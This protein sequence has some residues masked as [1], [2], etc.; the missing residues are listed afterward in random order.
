MSSPKDQNTLFRFTSLRSPELV[1]KNNQAQR[2]VFHPYLVTE[3]SEVTSAYF[4]AVASKPSDQSNWQAMKIASQTFTAYQS[5]SEIENLVPD[6]YYEDAIFLAKNKMSLDVPEFYTRISGYTPVTDENLV[7]VW[8]N[9]FY[10]VITQ[11]DFYIKDAILE[12]LVFQNLLR[13]IAGKT[14]D[15][16]IALI[17]VLAKA[18]VVLPNILF[19][20]EINANIAS[21]S[22]PGDEEEGTVLAAYNF[23]KANDV[24]LSQHN[25]ELYT[26]TLEKI[27]TVEGLLAKDKSAKYKEAKATHR[28]KVKSLLVPYNKDYLDAKRLLCATAPKPGYD[29]DDF[30][31]QPAIDYPTL[32]DFDFKYTEDDEKLFFDKNVDSSLKNLLNELNKDVP[33]TTFQKAKDILNEAVSENTKF[34]FK[35]TKFSRQVVSIGDV[36][37]PLVENRG[38]S[39]AFNLCSIKN[40]ENGNYNPYVT[41]P[42]PDS[43]YSVVAFSYL[44]T[45][46]DSTTPLPGTSYNQTISN[47]TITLSKMFG[48]ANAIPISANSNIKSLSGTITFANGM[49]RTFNV[50]G[51]KVG[52]AC[53]LGKLVDK[54]AA[55][56]KDP[57]GNFVP[58]GFGYRQLGIADYRK[59]V[60]EVCCYDAGEVAH[61]ENIMAS[62]FKEKTTEKNYIRETTEFESEETETESLSDV[63]STQRF[64]M[65]T[66]IAKIMQQQ[67]QAEGHVNVQANY[68]NTSLDT[69]ASFAS[70][71]TREQSNRQALMQ[72]QEITQRATER[73][74]SRIKKEKTVKITESFKDINSHIFD[75]RGNDKHVSGVY[76]FIN[77]IYR[78]QIYNYGKRLMYEFM[79]PQPSKLHRMGMTLVGEDKN[80][81]I[82]PLDPRKN[83]YADFSAIT[84]ANYQHLAAEYNAQVELYPAD[85][86]YVG[87]SIDHAIGAVNTAMAKSST[88]KIPDERYTSKRA[89][90]NFTGAPPGGE[91]GWGKSI[92]LT[93]GGITWQFT[94]WDGGSSDRDDDIAEYVKEVPVSVTMTNFLAF[95]LQITIECELSQ[96][97]VQQW[98]KDTFEAIIKGYEEQLRIFNEKDQ[99]KKASGVQ[100]LD[101]NPLFYREIEQ[102]VLRKNCIS[103]LID[104]SLN[105]PQR[106][107][108]EMYK[109]I[110]AQSFTNLQVNLDQKMDDYSSLA[111]FMEQAF[112]WNLISYNF[113]PYYWASDTDWVKLYQF[114]SNDAVF[115]NFMQAGMARVV[116][117]VKPGFEDAVLHYM[118][119]GQIW[120]GGQMPVLGDPL[121]LSIVDE[122]KEQE[123]EIEETWTTV[124]PT[125]LIALQ[126]S[127]VALNVEGLPCSDDCDDE[128]DHQFDKND[129][130]LEREN[131]N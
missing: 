35:N 5:V 65:Q 85:K 66:E 13:G 43:S 110:P 75:N 126:K 90:V 17:P 95:N 54:D 32:P 70:N 96:Q 86:I 123:Y 98:K 58:K 40:G 8:D 49:V 97:G 64:E 37:F 101:S 114:D 23:Q 128:V 29:R 1:E 63:V 6:H 102:M 28:A 3:P 94:E 106:F 44:L 78:N 120:N 84:P 51:F 79:V 4:N 30:C 118:A 18:R 19:D 99:E 119:F 131:K 89:M 26:Q 59:V 27:K 15:E 91:T 16:A 73:I 104:N 11:K 52:V 113:Y 76:R 46:V 53:E 39:M 31:N 22:S 14:E 77:A 45:Y 108:Q 92:W 67:Q 87:S 93:V 68:T 41:I 107:G 100:I 83:G 88:I 105:S 115:R 121:Y 80:N 72:A 12:V 47:N 125:N 34:V 56:V 130:I 25:V 55:P 38:P 112:E 117:S 2:F 69:G 48:V 122:L 103:Y 62:E 20:Q 24:F 10:Q 129:N 74:V 71:T 21:K 50:L 109:T 61:I 81:I 116:V 127:G 124:L 60:S 33:V 42:M 36:S 57:A 111:K 7:N 82:E 9:L